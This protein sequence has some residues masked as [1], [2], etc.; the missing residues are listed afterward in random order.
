M[1]QIVRLCSF[2]LALMMVF[3]IAVG[4]SPAPENAS[5]GPTSTGSPTEPEEKL[6]ID[7]EQVKAI[8]TILAD[9]IM[10]AFPLDQSNSLPD[11]ILY[12]T[13]T[14]QILRKNS[15]C[16]L[17]LFAG[18]TPSGEPMSS[19]CI[20]YSPY[21]RFDNLDQLYQ[22]LTADGLSDSQ[23]SGITRCFPLNSEIGFILPDPQR[24]VAVTLPEI[25][26]ISSVKVYGEDLD[27]YY[28]EMDKNYPRLA[29]NISILDRQKFQENMKWYNRFRAD[30]GQYQTAFVIPELNAIAY[31]CN[32]PAGV[33]RFVQ[34]SVQTESKT[35]FI[36][37][38]YAIE[39]SNTG[40]IASDT[41]PLDITVF[42]YENGYYFSISLSGTQM[43]PSIEFLDSFHFKAYTPQ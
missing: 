3:S 20:V 29:G 12:E 5:T 4:C 27:Y 35:L 26:E 38:R 28:R 18:N 32:V 33:F 8:Q 14:Y 23:I 34:Y 36:E 43:R 19:G 11:E 21:L 7:E 24:L 2:V 25:L 30:P 13:D 6:K 39:R 10:R 22:T 9:E 17:N 15:Q 37:E 1:K 31:D 16:Y 40:A 41:V 42:G